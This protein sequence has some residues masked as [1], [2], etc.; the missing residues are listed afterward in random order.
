MLFN[1]SYK[2]EAF[3]KESNLAIGESYSFL[4]KLKIGGIGS[5]RMRIKELSP[6]LTP[7]NKQTTDIDYASIE[8]RPRGIL[9]HF[10][11]RLDRYSWVI[12][13]YR[14]VIFSTKTF[15]IHSNGNFIRFEKNKNYLE[16]KK[17]INKMMNLKNL[18]LDH[19]YYNV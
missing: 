17:F 3:E 4:E 15:S 2:N 10:S 18:A 6:K 8:L 11:N 7:L 1:T 12:P 14:L 9:I 19:E 13:Y 5:S 16:N